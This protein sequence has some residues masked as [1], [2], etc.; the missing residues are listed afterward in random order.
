[1][2]SEAANSPKTRA[3]ASV[4][5]SRPMQL[6]LMARSGNR[7][8]SATETRISPIVSGVRTRVKIKAASASSRSSIDPPAQAKASRL[9]FRL[10]KR[11]I[12]A[13]NNACLLGKRA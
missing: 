2:A 6:T 4:G 5:R 12:T 13:V 7:R 11:S 1:M 3:T 8:A 10:T 9:V